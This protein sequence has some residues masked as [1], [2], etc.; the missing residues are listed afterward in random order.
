M[1]WPLALPATGRIQRDWSNGFAKASSAA[2]IRK[3]PRQLAA[4]IDDG[5]RTELL[6]SITT[7]TLVLHGEA[8]PLVKLEGGRATAEAITG[9]V[10]KTYAGWGHDLPTELI[11]S[12]ADA[13]A[14][15]AHGVE[16][17]R[18]AA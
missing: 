16:S 11:E 5:D 3:V 6:K 14:E 10:L 17:S 7:P 4:I 9:S 13:I 12:F 15:H 18:A 1:P 2:S 8:D